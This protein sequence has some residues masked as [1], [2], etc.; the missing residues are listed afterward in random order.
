MTA[1]TRCLTLSFLFASAAWAGPSDPPKKG[2]KP[3]ATPKPLSAL[4]A[5]WQER[6]QEL[7]EPYSYPYLAVTPPKPFRTE[8]YAQTPR[9]PP[10]VAK[11][12][13]VEPKIPPAPAPSE[14]VKPAGTASPANPALPEQ[15][16]S[17]TPAKP[18]LNPEDE[19]VQFFQRPDNRRGDEKNLGPAFDPTF[20][21]GA[22]PA[23]APNTSH[24]TYKVE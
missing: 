5:R 23:P 3:A 6:W 7:W 12:E 1:F 8:G 4:A 19:A 14:G 21:Q 18:K 16:A 9:N 11:L 20:E 24:A 15:D 10:P 22:A 2:S 13:I 17:T